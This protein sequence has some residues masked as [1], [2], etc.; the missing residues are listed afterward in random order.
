MSAEE[1][2]KSAGFK[3]IKND[4]GED[5][6]LFCNYYHLSSDKTEASCNLNGVRFLGN[7]EA[8]EHICKKFDGS[9]MDSLFKELAQENSKSATPTNRKPDVQASQKGGGGSIKFSKSSA[10]D[11]R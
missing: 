1:R 8:S 6:C 11:N 3:K 9:T 7:F 2:L 10:R 4:N 5:C